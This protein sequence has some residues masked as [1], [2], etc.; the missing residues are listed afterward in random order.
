MQSIC[1]VKEI[2]RI[3]TNVAQTDDDTITLH[4]QVSD[5]VKALIDLIDALEWKKFTIL[6]ESNVW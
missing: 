4:P 6:I 3:A 5:T 2:P 1:D